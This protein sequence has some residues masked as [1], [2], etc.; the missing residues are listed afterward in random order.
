MKF[1]N[2]GLMKRFTGYVKRRFNTLIGLLAGTVKLWPI[3][4]QLSDLYWKNVLGKA[5][6]QIRIRWDVIISH[7]GNCLIGDRVF[8]G[9]GCR[10]YANDRIEIGSDTMLAAECMLITR[11]HIYTD[12]QVSISSQGH[13]TAPIVIGRDVWVGFRCV[14]LPG[15]TIGDGAVVAAGAV[16]TKD[17]PSHSIVGGVPARIIGKRQLRKG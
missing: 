3:R 2:A 12:P 17:V 1:S 11:N 16:V 6:K 4:R 10:L 15:V 13:K 9:D 14:V 8:I 5:G 7:P